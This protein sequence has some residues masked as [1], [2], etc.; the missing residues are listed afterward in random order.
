[1]Q[2]PRGHH[3]VGE[4]AAAGEQRRVFDALHS[5]AAA[6]AAGF[7]GRSVHVAPSAISCAACCT[8]ATMLV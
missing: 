3:V 8:E 6:E 7:E 1:M 2:L 4:L 5:L